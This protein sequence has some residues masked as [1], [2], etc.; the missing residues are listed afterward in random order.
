MGRIYNEYYVH[1]AWGNK[2][3]KGSSAQLIVIQGNLIFSIYYILYV[4]VVQ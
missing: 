1:V 3:H 4:I 2:K